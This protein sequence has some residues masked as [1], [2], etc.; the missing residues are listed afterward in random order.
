MTLEPQWYLNGVGPALRG[1]P[2]D[3]IMSCIPRTSA[4]SFVRSYRPPVS[5]VITSKAPGNGNFSKDNLTPTTFFERRLV[6][7]LR[8]T[9]RITF[10]VTFRFI[11][12]GHGPRPTVPAIDDGVDGFNMA[13][14]LPAM[15]LFLKN[16]GHIPTC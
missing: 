14:L 4:S 16:F 7:L 8:K 5:I 11:V 15:V 2:S 3:V 10:R 9:F 1:S 6:P 13:T 12:S